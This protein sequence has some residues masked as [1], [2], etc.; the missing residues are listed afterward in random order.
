MFEEELFGEEDP[1]NWV[2]TEAGVDMEDE[3][4]VNLP[5][6]SGGLDRLKTALGSAGG[7]CRY[8]AVMECSIQA[9][10]RLRK[11]QVRRRACQDVVEVSQPCSLGRSTR[12]QRVDETRELRIAVDNEAVGEL[13][14]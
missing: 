8:P 10:K 12:C 4:E 14:V 7:R 9:P 11:F 5:G 2:M 1:K 6:V 13:S 3:G